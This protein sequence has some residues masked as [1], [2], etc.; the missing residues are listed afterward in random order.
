MNKRILILGLGNI[1]ISD[2]GLGVHALRWLEA[3]CKLPPKVEL[4]DGGTGG[5]RF[6]HYYPRL[7]GSSS[8]MPSPLVKNLGQ[9]TAFPKKS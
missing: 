7:M 1:L 3:N 2:E 6:Y 8:S 9:S 4:V 5:S